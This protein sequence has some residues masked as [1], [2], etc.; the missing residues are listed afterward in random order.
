[1]LEKE[2]FANLFTK[3][4]WIEYGKLLSAREISGSPYQDWRQDY[5]GKAGMIVIVR[6]P[7]EENER[8]LFFPCVRGSEAQP[9]LYST[10]GTIERDRNR[11]DIR[12]V[13]SVY[14][15]ELGSFGMSEEDMCLLYLNALA[16]F[17]IVLPEA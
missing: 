9:Y 14:Q 7:D 12:T 5:V 11:I 16:D 13:H 2:G 6:L 3:D 17:G 10:P 8:V 15:F 1:M 4:S